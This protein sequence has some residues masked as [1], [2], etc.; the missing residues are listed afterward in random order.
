MLPSQRCNVRGKVM[1]VVSR[2]NNPL[3]MINRELNAAISSPRPNLPA[4]VGTIDAM[5]RSLRR[6]VA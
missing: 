5:S 2:A 3:E 6:I 1:G 4:F